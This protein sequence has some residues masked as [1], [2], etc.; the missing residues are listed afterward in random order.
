VTL[1]ITAKIAVESWLANFFTGALFRLDPDLSLHKMLDGIAIPNGITWS[2]DSKTM[3]VSDSPTRNIYAFDYDVITGSISNKRVFFH[4]ED[5][6]GQPDGQALDEFGCLWSAIFGLGKVVRL[7]PA[8]EVV[9][10]VALPTRCVTCPVFVDDWIYVTSAEEEEPERFPGSRR[11]QGAVFRCKVGV[12]G[13]DVRS[14]KMK[15]RE[16]QSASFG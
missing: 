15:G 4:V 10:T 5:A 14:F 7:S 3:F 1:W 12:R 16:A 9:A 2:K 8:G 11:Y 6:D 13:F